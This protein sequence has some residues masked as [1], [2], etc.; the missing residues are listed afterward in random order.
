MRGT[1]RPRQRAGGRGVQVCLKL[2]MC[3]WSNG[4]RCDMARPD[5]GL[6]RSDPNPVRT[7][8]NPQVSR[9]PVALLQDVE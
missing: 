2:F 8:E 6:W 9:S 7:E 5:E 3:A 1:P 4:S